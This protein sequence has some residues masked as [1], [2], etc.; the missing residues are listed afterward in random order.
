MDGKS[1][2]ATT[3]S[4]VVDT[5]DSFT[6]GVVVRLA[7][8]EPAGPVTV[9]FQPGKHTDVFTVRH[10]PSVHAWQLVMPRKDRAGAPEVVVSRSEAPDGGEGP[11]HRLAVAYDDATDRIKLHLDGCTNDGATASFPGSPP[12][13]GALRIGRSHVGDGRGDH[14]HGD[15]DEVQA[16]A[17]APRAVWSTPTTDGAVRCCTTAG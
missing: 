6:L 13:S 11:G 17:V 9:R 10:D 2:Y 8:S 4:A 3:G 12:S 7:D 1:G 16:Y 5:T 15:V 14:L